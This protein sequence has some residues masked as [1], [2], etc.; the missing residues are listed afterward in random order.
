DA[1][2][3]H[4]IS[5]E[6]FADGHLADRIVGYGIAWHE[7]QLFG[8]INQLVGVLTALGL[9]TMAVT[10]FLLWRRRKPANRLGPP[11]PAPVPPR[12]TGVVAIL[13]LLAALLP[14]LA[15]SLLLLWLFERLALPRLPA[16]ARWLGVPAPG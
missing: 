7:G 15:G 9:V 16:L 5:R 3:G 12:M 8:W 14:M 11:P 6:G 2:T 4:Q 13:L 1:A 10:G